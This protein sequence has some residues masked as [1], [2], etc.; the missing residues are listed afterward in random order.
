MP[1]A[2]KLTRTQRRIRFRFSRE[3]ETTGARFERRFQLFIALSQT[4]LI[5]IV[6]FQI[7]DRGPPVFHQVSLVVRMQET[8]TAGRHPAQFVV[9]N[10][11]VIHAPVGELV[12]V[13]Q[14]VANKKKTSKTLTSSLTIQLTLT[15]SSSRRH[16]SIASDGCRCS[17]SSM[18]RFSIRLT[19]LGRH[20]RLASSNRF[21]HLPADTAGT[22]SIYRKHSNLW[23]VYSLTP[24]NSI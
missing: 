6:V 1:P 2:S 21:T 13:V 18:T 9:I 19:S 24:G 22:S 7:P 5:V 11:E 15:G 3:T 4:F 8:E 16:C 23:K 12:T 20:S 17:K 14:L 10:A